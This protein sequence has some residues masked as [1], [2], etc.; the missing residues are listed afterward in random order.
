MGS[1]SSIPLAGV[2]GA[3]KGLEKAGIIREISV[4]A[5]VRPHPQNQ[6]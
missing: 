2:Q 6:K 5:I 1:A 3:L 4:Q